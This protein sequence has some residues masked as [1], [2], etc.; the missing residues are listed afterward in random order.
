MAKKVPSIIDL[1]KNPNI[2][3]RILSH[4]SELTT[5]SDEKPIDLKNRLRKL[6]LTNYP[7]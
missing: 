2:N 4:F 5:T 3:E 7:G 1:L 6:E